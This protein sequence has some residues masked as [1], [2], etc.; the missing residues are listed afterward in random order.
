V[1]DVAV[2]VEGKTE[3]TFVNGLLHS[4]FADRGIFIWGRLPGRRI[5]Q[6]GV[7]GWASVRGDVFRVLK[8]RAGRV[9]TTMFDFYGMPRDWPGRVQAAGEPADKKGPRVEQA[10]L[11]DLC[12][13]ASKDFRPEWFIP[14]VQVH[15]FEA[16][17]F[18]DTS[19]AADELATNPGGPPDLADRLQA[20]LEAAGQPEAI[21]D[22]WETCPSRRIAGLVAGYRKPLHGAIAAARIGLDAMRQACPHFGQWIERLERLS[23]VQ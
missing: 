6:G 15:E 2:I 9:C 22:N 21:N 3:E 13:F 17:L 16:L 8:E 7:R 5:R 18:S 14:Y 11:E 23:L 1:T 20:I 19:R 10:L 12:K 4:H